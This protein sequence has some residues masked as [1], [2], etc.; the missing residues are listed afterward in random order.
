MAG[1][2]PTPPDCPP[3]LKRLII[4]W[5]ESTDDQISQFRSGW[6]GPLVRLRHRLASHQNL[7]IRKLAGVITL[8]NRLKPAAVI[9]LGQHGPIL[10]R[11]LKRAH[12]SVKCIWYAADE[13]INFQLS[14]LPHL[15]IRQWGRRLR[16]IGIYALLEALFTRNL[17]GAIGVSPKDTLLLKWLAGVRHVRTIRNGVD[18]DY[19]SATQ[20]TSEV[21]ACHANS[22]HSLVFWGRL[23]FEPNIDAVC[24]FANRIWPRL[25]LHWPNATW[26]IVGKNADAR[27]KAACNRPGIMLV[28]EVPDIRPEAMSAS[29]TILPLRCGAGIKNKLLEAAALGR[30]IL[31]STSTVRGLKLPPRALPIMICHNQDDWLN[32]MRRL[33]NDPQQCDQLGKTARQWVERNH[34]WT[35]AARELLRFLNRMLPPEQMILIDPA[36]DQIEDEKLPTSMHRSAPIPK[37]MAA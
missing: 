16:L 19:F 17:D 32:C 23:D 36:P 33:W 1:M 35:G 26:R 7:D 5:P 18:L 12:P 14:C 20:P 25:R 3:W 27:V 31:A 9:A 37:G 28:G 4:D 10:L 2:Q 11:G 22:N 21:Q 13:P 30:P 29:I 24:W 15:P 6:R 34:T 8:V